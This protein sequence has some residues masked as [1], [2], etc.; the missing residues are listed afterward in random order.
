MAAQ[1]AVSREINQGLVGTVQEVLVEKNG[2]SREYPLAGRA[3]R[4]APDVDGIT[5]LRARNAHPGD[6]VLCRI[7]DADE[8]DLFG[9]AIP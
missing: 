8:Y 7:V 5:Y 4:Q 9:E 2:L 3:R 6:F 1:A